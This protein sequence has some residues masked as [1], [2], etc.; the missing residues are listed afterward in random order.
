MIL[1]VRLLLAFHRRTCS[2]QL[3]PR[4]GK[5]RSQL[6]E[7]TELSR[8]LYCLNEVCNCR[9]VT[10][11]ELAEVARPFLPNGLGTRLDS[12]QECMYTK[13]C[14]RSHHS[15]EAVDHGIVS[16]QC[17]DVLQHGR[18][19]LLSRP[20]Q[21]HRILYNSSLVPRCTPANSLQQICDTPV[22]PHGNL[23]T[24]PRHPCDTPKT[25]Q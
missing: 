4:A 23:V 1:F 22:T 8:G 24:P 21:N 5:D 3:L 11:F 2:K 7:I 12:S 19:L 9:D 16:T 10:W 15:N 6:V 20:E 25:P 14:T 17:L 13:T 18:H